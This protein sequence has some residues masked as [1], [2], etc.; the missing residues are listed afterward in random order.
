MLARFCTVQNQAELP[1]QRP[2]TFDLVIN[3]KTAKGTWLHC[4]ARAAHPRR[5][6]DRMSAPISG[7]GTNRTSSDV[8]S[9]VA[10]RGIADM[11]LTARF[12]P[13]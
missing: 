6:G 8:R 11:A 4:T 7:I 1:L 12:G 2:E 9:S 13:E 5:R 10:I 3:L